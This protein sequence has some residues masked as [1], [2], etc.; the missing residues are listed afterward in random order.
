M[1]SRWQCAGVLALAASVV[2]G[3]GGAVTGH[4]AAQQGGPRHIPGSLGSMLLPAAQFPAAY[5]ALVL[6]V[7]SAIEAAGDINAAAQDVQVEPSRCALPAPAAEPPAVAVG[8]SDDVP[9]TLTIA[10]TRV[11]ES[12]SVR[13]AQLH[14]CAIATITDGGAKS[15]LSSQILPAP[16]VAADDT[17]ALRQTRRPAAGGQPQQLTTLQAQHGDIR[18]T[19]TYL[20][21]T[22]A[23]PDTESLDT[24]FTAAVARVR[25]GK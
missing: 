4:P 15:T 14:E 6:P 10:L 23:E 17:L 22:G 19:A 21:F 16:P 3:C 9:A 7:P 24:V 25:T 5:P 8:T 20:A 2:T 13:K 18:I 11:S 1:S 12:L